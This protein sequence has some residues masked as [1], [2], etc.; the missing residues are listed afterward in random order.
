MVLHDLSAAFDITDQHTLSYLIPWFGIGGTTRKW[1]DSYLSN[2]CQAIKI[3]STLAELGKL[4]NGVQQSS[5][6]CPLN[7]GLVKPASSRCVTL[8][9]LIVVITIVA[10][11]L[12]VYHVSIN[13]SCRVFRTVF[14]WFVSYPSDHCQA[15]KLGFT[16]F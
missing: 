2:H 15:I 6:L 5:M 12:Q 9:W 7:T 13:R 1:F 10:L 3:G 8:Q 14:K 16:L 4:I 11:C